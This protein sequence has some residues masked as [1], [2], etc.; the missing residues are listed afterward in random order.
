MTNVPSFYRFL[1]INLRKRMS[2]LQLNECDLARRANL[3]QPTVHK[4]LTGKTTDPRFSTIKALANCLNLSI[5]QLVSNTPT[6]KDV[7]EAQPLTVLT[8]EDCLSARPADDE[9]REH[10]ILN[11]VSP[12][13]FALRSKPA[14]LSYFPI[15]TYLIINP[16]LKP[17]D[18][19]L[20][21]LHYPNTT[22]ATLRKLTLDGPTVLLHSLNESVENH[23]LEDNIRILGVVT[24]RIY[25]YHQQYSW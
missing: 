16:D 21:V 4:I 7:E 2:A 25:D 23:L 3:P 9:P 8:W 19:D 15:G 17:K 24:R 22:E 11:Y 20:I 13:A 18:G 12:N 6:L 5:E 14:M 10:I 1:E